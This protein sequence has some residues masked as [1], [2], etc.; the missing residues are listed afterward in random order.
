C[1]VRV[2]LP[3]DPA[4][5][6]SDAAMAATPAKRPSPETGAV[7][8]MVHEVPSQ[9]SARGPSSPSPTAP[10]AH[11]SFELTAAT[12]ARVPPPNGVG[13][14]TT[15]QVDPFQCSANVA[16]V[17]PTAPTAHASDGEMA[18]TPRRSLLLE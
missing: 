16:T 3:F 11:T 12:A 4:A 6:T 5:H 2:R 18:A 14:G 17:N 8:T 7:G 15:A 10:T 13:V 1:W 9:C